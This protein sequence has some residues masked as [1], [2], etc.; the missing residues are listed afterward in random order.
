MQILDSSLWISLA[1]G[2]VAIRYAFTVAVSA[3]VEGATALSMLT[4]ALAGFFLILAVHSF[5]DIHD[6]AEDRV[7]HPERPL[8]A[9][10]ITV[11]QARLFGA[12]TLILSLSL[13]I[14]HLQALIIIAVITAFVVIP[15]LHRLMQEHWYGRSIS[16]FLFIFSAFLL[17][18][19]STA[20]LPSTRLLLLALAISTLHLASRVIRDEWDLEGDSQRPLRTLPHVNL[21][22]ARLWVRY[23]LIAAAIL[24]LLPAFFNFHILYLLLAGPAS[25]AIM[26]HALRWDENHSASHPSHLWAFLVLIGAMLGR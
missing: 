14:F 18:S 2:T 15:P 6:L 24:L 20:D 23:N 12:A 7:N 25:L 4:L 5:D 26:G 1:R 21:S 13:A 19:T 8:P 16:I 22:L 3:Y 17:G 11:S 9:G 10:K